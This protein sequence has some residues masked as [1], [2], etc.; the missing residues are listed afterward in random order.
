MINYADDDRVCTNVSKI[1]TNV[2]VQA[3][4][5]VHTNII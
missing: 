3:S 4:G 1:L 2:R 5:I